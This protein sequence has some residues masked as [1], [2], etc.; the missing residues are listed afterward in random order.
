[1]YPRTSLF[2]IRI[3]RHN[4]LGYLPN[5]GKECLDLLAAL[6]KIAEQLPVAGTKPCLNLHRRV[7]VEHLPAARICDSHPEHGLAVVAAL[8]QLPAAVNRYWAGDFANVGCER[9][10][11][12]DH[13]LC[14]IE[15]LGER[16]K[17]MLNTRPAQP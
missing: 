11:R 10:R 13:G 15:H 7:M 2:N 1:M 12:S 6:L 17:V 9:E 5:A 3:S 8:D 14:Y 16:G 4:S